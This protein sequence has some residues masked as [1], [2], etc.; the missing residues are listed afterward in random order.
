M[1]N[2]KHLNLFYTYNRDTELIENNLTRAFIVFLSILSGQ[3]RNHFLRSIRLA[4]ANDPSNKIVGIGDLDFTAVQFALQG[5]IDPQIPRNA[6]RKILLTISTDSSDISEIDLV[7]TDEAN[8]ES[9]PD[10]WIYDDSRAFCILIESKIGTNPLD[11]NQIRRHV[12]NRFGSTLEEIKSTGSWYS[13]TWIDVLEILD[14]ILNKRSYSK[15]VEDQ[16][17]AHL[18]GFMNFLDIICLMELIFP[19]YSHPRIF[20]Y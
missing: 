8:G 12:S 15:S 17:I 20:D 14:V 3:T 1:S 6:T 4:K 7:P 10:G 2:D 13:T 19:G 18:M 11:M 5:N 16:L 9:T